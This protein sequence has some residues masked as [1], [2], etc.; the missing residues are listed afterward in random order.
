MKRLPGQAGIEEHPIGSGKYRVRARVDGKRLELVSGVSLAQAE[1]VAASYVVE[2]NATAH[3]QGI[4][5]ASFGA[6]FLERRE[7][8][9]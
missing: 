5:L 7:V 3:R 9:P 6:G 8:L 4:T 1:A 2:R